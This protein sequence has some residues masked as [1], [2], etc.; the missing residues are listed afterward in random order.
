MEVPISEDDAAREKSVARAGD[1]DEGILHG[2][3][4]HG[5][6]RLGV[7]GVSEGD[8]GVARFVRTH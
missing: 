5:A 7:G 6:P 3:E 1:G 2:L 4:L 8:Q